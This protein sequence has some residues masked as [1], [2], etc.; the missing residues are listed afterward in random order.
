MIWWSGG[1]WR[2][3]SGNGGSP[4]PLRNSPDELYVAEHVCAECHADQFGKHQKSG[5]ANTFRLSVESVL[6][7]HLAGLVFPDPERGYSYHYQLNPHSGLSVTVPELLGN[8]P[9]PLLYEFGSGQNAVTYLTLLPD[10]WGDTVGIEH[11]VSLYRAERG[12]ELDL[13]PGH[14]RAA[15]G[16][17][18]EQFGRVIRGDTLTRCIGCHTVT[19]EIA[20]Q[21]LTDLRPNVGCQSCHGP[22]R[23]HVA[24]Q[25]SEG[26]DSYAGFT[27]QAAAREIE[28]CG[29]C[30][31]LPEDPSNA[32]VSPNLIENIRFQ[33][34]GL[35]QSRCYKSSSDLRCTTCHDPHERVSRDRD[36]YV[37]R[38]LSCHGQ[39]ESTVCPVSPREN[40]ISCHMPA[41]AVH[42]D[43]KFHDH[44]IRVRTDQPAVEKVKPEP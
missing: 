33:P 10:R 8:D 1:L 35:I 42:R 11:R 5:H 20:G 29:R 37:R 21:Q 15:V 30:H 6:A 43:I 32:H 13:T 9:F 19:A 25:E 22:G 17:E 40:C 14:Q 38:C 31:R 27:S 2:G 23:E 26:V 24:A 4:S 36:H 34:A 3:T 28:L 12:L 18:V 16:Q 41:I 39:P 7:R 44:W